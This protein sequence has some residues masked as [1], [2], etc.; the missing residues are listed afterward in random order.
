MSNAEKEPP[1]TGDFASLLP[2][3]LKVVKQRVQEAAAEV[4]TTTRQVV[5]EFRKELEQELRAGEEKT[6]KAEPRKEQPPAPPADVN[7]PPDEKA[8]SGDGSSEGT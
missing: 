4:R 1:L 3:A 5:G 6:A 8:A 7:R 2:L